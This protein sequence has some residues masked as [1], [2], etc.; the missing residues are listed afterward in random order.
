MSEVEIETVTWRDRAA[1]LFDIRHRVFVVEQ[2]VPLELEHDAYDADALHLLARVEGHSVATGRLLDDGHIGRMAV[3]PQWRGR[4]IGTAMLRT[5]VAEAQRR[6]L[7]R[8]F[9][10]AQCD[11]IPFYER[12]GFVAEGEVFVD[13]GI[14][15]RTMGRGITMAED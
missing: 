11:A 10:H 12:L 6:G 13:A 4:G 2:G 14:D 8:V 9:L 5:L 15:H 7:R 1:E 3:L